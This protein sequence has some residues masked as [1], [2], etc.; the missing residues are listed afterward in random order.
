MGD[1]GRVVGVVTFISLV[2]VI[3]MSMSRHGGC[4]CRNVPAER[5]G[6]AGDGNVTSTESSTSGPER[7]SWAVYWAFCI[8]W[9]THTC[10]IAM[11]VRSLYVPAR[12]YM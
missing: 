2:E 6:S 11:K 4:G 7:A 10:G 3:K 1:G 12:V 5:G 9:H 8:T